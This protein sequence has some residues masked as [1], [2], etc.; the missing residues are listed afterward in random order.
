MKVIRDGLR[1]CGDC[2][3]AAVNDDFSGLDARYGP[4]EA[5]AIQQRIE[6]SLA[7]FGLHLVH[8]GEDDGH[9]WFNCDCCGAKRC[10]GTADLFAIL[11]EEGAQ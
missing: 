6:S 4:D 11:S 5:N 9:G 10:F 3:V 8:A 7:G 2:T 1:F